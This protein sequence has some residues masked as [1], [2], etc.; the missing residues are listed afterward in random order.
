MSDRVLKRGQ[1][2]VIAYLERD[3]SNITQGLRLKL[4]YHGGDGRKN[5]RGLSLEI[6]HLDCDAQKNCQ[7]QFKKFQFVF[8]CREKTSLKIFIFRL[9]ML[10]ISIMLNSKSKNLVL[11]SIN[12]LL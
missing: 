11:L 3:S 12:S 1:F 9:I 2:Q 7:G 6:P 4:A 5:S 8:Q 10:K